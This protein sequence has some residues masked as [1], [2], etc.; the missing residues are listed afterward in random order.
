MN[1]FDLFDAL[2]GIDEDL[3]ERSERRP[4]QKL[5][6]RKLLIAAAAVML[7]TVTALAS[8]GVQ[9]WFSSISILKV[10][11][12]SF[13]FHPDDTE[14]Y[15]EDFGRISLKLEGIGETPKTIEELRLPTF[16]Q[17]GNW[18]FSPF[19]RY[20]ERP[21][22]SGYWI[23]EKNNQRLIYDQKTIL[24]A[25]DE[26]SSG[27]CVFALDLGNDAALNSTTITVKGKP[28]Q[29]Y[30]VGASSFEGQ[31]PFDAHTDIFWSDGEYAY[32]IKSYG[33]ELE[34]LADILASIGPVPMEDYILLPRYE[35]IQTFYTLS[36]LP[37]GLTRS[38]AENQGHT[39]WQLWGN[40]L[41]GIC[42][43]QRRDQSAESDLY[44]D[45]IDQI[46]SFHTSKYLTMERTEVP[47]NGSTVYIL[48]SVAESF[49]CWQQDGCTFLMEIYGY[50]F[51]K[52]EMIETYVRSL[53]PAESWEMLMSE[54]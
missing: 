16:F 23:W 34:L 39:A 20:P 49:A 27:Y 46:L 53:T 29:V 15:L 3:L 50:P 21:F 41:Q 38:S 54:P 31:D 43:E 36:V 28:Y 40:T 9:E 11:R 19:V 37:S 2:G 4:I 22:I 6:F 14:F 10:D 17:S 30:Q 35:S 33:M 44:S 5:P 7:L 24:R 52:P 51:I 42:L 13:I 12:S 8:P 32:H 47:V 48:T 25:S 18:T 26:D 45:T 1:E